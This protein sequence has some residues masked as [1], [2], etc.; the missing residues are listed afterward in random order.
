MQL[1]IQSPFQSLKHRRGTPPP[2]QL[3]LFR[4]PESNSTQG[5]EIFR[6]KGST[7]VKL[8]TERE[9]FSSFTT[10]DRQ[11]NDKNMKQCLDRQLLVDLIFCGGKKNYF[12]HKSVFY[13]SLV[14]QQRDGK[15]RK[16]R[17]GLAILVLHIA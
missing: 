9:I 12:R 16:R 8:D 4:R 5:G 1:R 3:Q 7:S 17:L 2:P 10:E 15:L 11:M 6:L 13:S 14:Q